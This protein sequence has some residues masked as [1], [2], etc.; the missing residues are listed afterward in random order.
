MDQ[1]EAPKMKP[2]AVIIAREG[3]LIY[4]LFWTFKGAITCAMQVKDR[5]EIVE[6]SNRHTGQEIFKKENGV[7]RWA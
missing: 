5:F 6:V 3:R 1:R 4:K 7:E 2:Y